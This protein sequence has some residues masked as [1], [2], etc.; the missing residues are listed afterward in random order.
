MEL[1]VKIIQRAGSYEAWCPALPGC[2]IRAE[3]QK[4]AHKQI[5]LAVEGYIASMNVALPRE[6]AAMMQM[7]TTGTAA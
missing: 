6:L 7:E 5:R 2:R 4:Q 1:A 3:S